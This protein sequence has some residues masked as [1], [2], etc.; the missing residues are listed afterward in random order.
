MSKAFRL[1][2]IASAHSSLSQSSSV[3]TTQEGTEIN[4][5]GSQYCDN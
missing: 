1:A 4:T 2:E 5:Q 3:S